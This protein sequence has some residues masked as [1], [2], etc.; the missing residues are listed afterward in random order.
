MQSSEMRLWRGV[1]LP[2]SSVRC[3]AGQ[4]IPDPSL[5]ATLLLVRVLR[6]EDGDDQ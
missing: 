5:L 4:R 1:G 3:L 6:L 2:L